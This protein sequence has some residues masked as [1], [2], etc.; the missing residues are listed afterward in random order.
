MALRRGN[1]ETAKLGKVVKS[2]PKKVADWTPEQR[3]TFT[4]QSDRAMRQQ[5][6]RK[7]KKS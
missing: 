2:L 7:P 6:G 3:K 1:S 5:A 4:T